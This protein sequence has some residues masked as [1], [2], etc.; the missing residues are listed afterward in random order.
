MK[1]MS[2]IKRNEVGLVS[3]M[4]TM[5]MMI[6]IS[7]IVIGF[8]QVSNRNRRE[9]LD[10]QLSTQAFYAAESGV[11]QAIAAIKSG[12][13]TT[14]QTNCTHLDYGGVP[15]TL[16]A[17]PG[18]D[19]AVTC[20]LVNPVSSSIKTTAKQ[21]G[22]AV[23]PITPVAS[24]GTPKNLQDLTFTW[25]S[26]DSA[27]NPAKCVNDFTAGSFPADI[28]AGANPCG[29]GLLRVDLMDYNSLNSIKSADTAAGQTAT[30]YFTPGQASQPVAALSTIS[31]KPASPKAYIAEASCNP[32][33][34]S[35]TIAFSPNA[36][37]LYA[38]ISTLYKDAPSV[39]ITGTLP[40]GF[41]AAY[42]KGIYT[43]DATG[44]AQDVLRRVQV[45]YNPDQAS[46]DIPYGALQ[47]SADVCKRLKVV[48]PSS[49]TSDP[50][51]P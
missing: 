29:Y 44:R 1:S 5:I 33:Q 7:L 40:A 43:I 24:N 35:A 48:S 3:I 47:T 34:C 17:S 9:A 28:S 8:T 30:F 15:A 25:N 12:A 38:R 42:F 32:A 2:S 16:S 41:G 37:A 46:N 27:P 31:I 51:C 21:G 20:L 4:V 39:T 45:R 10:Q 23:V 19:V 6:V 13:S 26:P 36:S 11:N 14:A 18:P 49:V 22:S 50:T